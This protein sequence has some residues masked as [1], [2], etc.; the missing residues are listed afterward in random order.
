[1]KI[2]RSIVH[3]YLDGKKVY[4][5]CMLSIAANWIIFLYF[6]DMF[7]YCVVPILSTEYLILEYLKRHTKSKSDMRYS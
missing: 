6:I 1:M 2:I 7:T 5:F 4:L 3:N